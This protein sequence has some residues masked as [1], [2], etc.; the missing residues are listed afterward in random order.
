MYSKRRAQDL[1]SQKLKWPKNVN[2]EKMELFDVF[3][4][5]IIGDRLLDESLA[6]SEQE[7]LYVKSFIGDS[8]RAYAEFA[9]H[10]AQ[11]IVDDDRKKFLNIIDALISSPAHN[12]TYIDLLDPIFITF[13]PRYSD[14]FKRSHLFCDC[15]EYKNG[16]VNE[17]Y[18]N[19]DRI[20]YTEMPVFAE[21]L[22]KYTKYMEADIVPYTIKEVLSKKKCTKKIK[23]HDKKEKLKQLYSCS[24]YYDMDTVYSSDS[25]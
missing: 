17:W 21:I 16:S 10:V 1:K 15:Y 11:I 9:R 23:P 14:I 2:E 22:E 8:K 3:L 13:E 20:V 19:N 7:T 6:L 25:Q 18:K 4:N 24:L 5:S 12:S